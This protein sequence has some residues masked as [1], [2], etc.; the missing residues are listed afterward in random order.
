MTEPSYKA[1]IPEGKKDYYEDLF[2]S[3]TVDTFLNANLSSPPDRPPM[4]ADLVNAMFLGTSPTGEDFVGTRTSHTDDGDR[5]GFYFSGSADWVS[6]R[7][8]ASQ[9]Y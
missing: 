6:V 1:G 9:F 4:N 8:S 3:S 7:W 5:D 2:P